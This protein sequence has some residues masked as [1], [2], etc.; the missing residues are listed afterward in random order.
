[1]YRQ[2]GWEWEG[3]DRGSDPRCVLSGTRAALYG[4]KSA[5]KMGVGQGGNV[6]KDPQSDDTSED[7]RWTID[8]AE[9]PFKA[10]QDT[11]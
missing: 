7:A 2:R 3:S 6:G 4:P 1:M 9:S 5:A 10:N 11:Q 8:L